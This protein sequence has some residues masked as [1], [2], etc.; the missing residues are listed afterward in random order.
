MPINDDKK[1]Y[2]MQKRPE[3]WQ[4]KIKIEGLSNLAPMCEA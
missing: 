2:P 3:K 4:D 1:N